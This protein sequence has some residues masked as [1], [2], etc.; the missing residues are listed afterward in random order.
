MVA[1]DDQPLNFC[2]VAPIWLWREDEL[3][4]ADNGVFI[5]RRK[6]HTLAPC[7]LM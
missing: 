3:H 4:R 5:V 2:A 1:A 6:N 7:G